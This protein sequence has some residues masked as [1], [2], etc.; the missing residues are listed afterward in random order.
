MS[1]KNYYYFD[2][3]KCEFIELEYNTLERIIYTASLW[4]LCGVV[5][6]GLGIITLSF[7]AGTPAEIA[8]KAEKTELLNQL[9]N[10]QETINELDKQMKQLANTDNQLYRTVLGMEPISADERKAGT[11]GTDVYEEFD[12]YSKE[13]AEILRWTA[14]S[15]D[16]LKR[17]INIQQMSLEEIKAHYNKNQERLKHMPAIKPTKGIL[18][19]GYGVRFHP[20]LKYRRMHEG[21]D[22][23]AR[24]GTPVYATG[25]GIIKF[26]GRNGTFGKSIEIDHNFGIITRYAHLS[27]YAEGIRAGTKVKRGQ[28][29]GYSG[30]TG[31]TNGPHLHYEIHKNGKSVDPLNY[32]FAEITP[33]EYAT[34]MKIA[35]NN[36]MD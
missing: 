25:D 24:V 30:N 32:L 13:T 22:F 28:L 20:V 18:I 7:Y 31:M 4:I 11:G 27:K 19:S 15:I 6:A 29:I 21:L 2:E 3:D 8:L 9:E 26:S 5:I 17:R 1:L 16:D 34:Y 14:S 36:P 10:T 23:R 12:V 35:E 33:S